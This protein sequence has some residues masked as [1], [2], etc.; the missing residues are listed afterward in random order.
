VRRVRWQLAPQPRSPV[1]GVL[2]PGGGESPS[3][4]RVKL[5]CPSLWPAIAGISVRAGRVSGAGLCSPF[6]NFHF[7]GAETGSTAD[8][9]WFA[10]CPSGI[11]R[12]AGAES[13]ASE[14]VQYTMLGELDFFDCLFSG[15]GSHVARP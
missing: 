10:E 5:R 9:D 2:F 7:G 11:G 14:G 15:G 3:F 8:R 1:S 4:P 12:D 13:T 6:F